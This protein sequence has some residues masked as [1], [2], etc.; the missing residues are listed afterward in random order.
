MTKSMK[1]KAKTPINS[2]RP[3]EYKKTGGHCCKPLKKKK[4]H[5]TLPRQYSTV[6]PL[7]SQLLSKRAKPGDDF[8]IGCVNTEDLFFLQI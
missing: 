8:A 4:Q 2:R 6:N 7:I 3:L 1:L 5:T